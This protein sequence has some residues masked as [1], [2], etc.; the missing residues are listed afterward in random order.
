[1]G[2]LFSNAWASP[3]DHVWGHF[4]E[5]LYTEADSRRRNGFL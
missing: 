4:V 1:M 2:S 3:F 5:H